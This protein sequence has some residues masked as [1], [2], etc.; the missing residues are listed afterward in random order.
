MNRYLIVYQCSIK[1]MLSTDITDRF[2]FGRCLRP[3]RSAL[4]CCTDSRNSCTTKELLSADV[5][6]FLTLWILFWNEFTVAWICLL[7]PRDIWYPYLHGFNQLQNRHKKCCTGCQTSR[8]GCRHIMPSWLSSW[9]LDFVC[10]VTWDPWCPVQLTAA[11]SLMTKQTKLTSSVV[12][13][14]VCLPVCLMRS[15]VPL[16]IEWVPKLLWVNKQT[17]RLQS[18]CVVGLPVCS[19]RHSGA[20]CFCKGRQKS[21]DETNKI[22]VFSRCMSILLGS[23]EI[24]CWLTRFGLVSVTFD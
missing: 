16:C 15:V 1:R 2:S 24:K 13:L 21:N 10:L 20:L 11:K 22:E 4:C 5:V 19:I 23:L 18:S 9:W 6:C 8:E 14:S 7:S 3:Q 12:V 17:L